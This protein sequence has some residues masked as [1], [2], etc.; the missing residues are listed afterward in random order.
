MRAAIFRKG[1]FVVGTLPDPVLQE[2]QV[3]VKTKACGICGSD[4]HAAKF[5]QQFADL[6][7]RSGGRFTMSVDRD[8]VF[9]HEFVAEINLGN[10]SHLG[11]VFQFFQGTEQ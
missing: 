9:G 7:R 6:G 3:L 4:L 5:P 1:D 10:F 11:G 8:I 2:G